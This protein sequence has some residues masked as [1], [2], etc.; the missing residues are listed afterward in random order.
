MADS[1]QTNGGLV[2]E[3]GQPVGS[4]AQ[5]RQ[6]GAKIIDEQGRTIRDTASQASDMGED[7]AGMI[8][9]R[10]LTAA[11]IAVGIGIVIGRLSA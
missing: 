2:D 3:Q 9:E 11:L 4:A 7:L 6:A 1:S 8:R 5:A 10:P